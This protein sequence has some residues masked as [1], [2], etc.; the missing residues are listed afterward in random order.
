[1][2]EGDRTKIWQCVTCGREF[3]KNRFLEWHTFCI[4]YPKVTIFAILWKKM[5]L[6][7]FTSGPSKNPYPRYCVWI[8]GWI[9]LTDTWVDGYIPVLGYFGSLRKEKEHWEWLEV[10]IDNLGLF[11]EDMGQIWPISAQDRNVLKR[12]CYYAHM[13]EYFDTK[14]ILTCNILICDISH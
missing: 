1:M 3:Q 9:Y 10:K 7:I 4:A 5:K 2:G 6:P 12:V 13:S 14:N 11:L 8:N